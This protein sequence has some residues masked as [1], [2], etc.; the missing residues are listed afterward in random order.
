[1][2]ANLSERK[3]IISTLTQ[4][5]TSNILLSQRQ[6]SQLT[7]YAKNKCCIATTKVNTKIHESKIYIHNRRC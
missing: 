4:S 1:M 6:N 2:Y 7:K 5:M 3:D